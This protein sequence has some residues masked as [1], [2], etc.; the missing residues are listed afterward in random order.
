MQ[1]QACLPPHEALG[2]DEAQDRGG[3]GGGDYVR[4]EEKGAQAVQD[5]EVEWL[6]WV[7]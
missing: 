5:L 2:R 4:G 1:A 7:P 3:L 6:T